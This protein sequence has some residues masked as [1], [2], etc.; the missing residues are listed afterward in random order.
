VKAGA[1]RQRLLAT[2]RHQ[3]ASRTT[4]RSHWTARPRPLQNLPAV[5]A[6]LSL[7]YSNDPIEGASIKVKY[8]KP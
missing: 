3:A 5:L 6:R 8:L 2:I 7:P 1:W 4:T